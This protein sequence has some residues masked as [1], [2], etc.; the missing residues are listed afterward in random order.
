MTQWKQ[1]P[2]TQHQPGKTSGTGACASC[3]GKFELLRVPVLSQSTFQWKQRTNKAHHWVPSPR[4]CGMEGGVRSDA[5]K[6]RPWSNMRSLKKR[7]WT[8][9]FDFAFLTDSSWASARAIA[10]HRGVGSWKIKTL[11]HSS[12]LDSAVYVYVKLSSFI[13]SSHPS[14]FVIALV[15]LFNFRIGSN[16]FKL[17]QLLPAFVRMSDQRRSF[18]PDHVFKASAKFVPCLGCLVGND[19]AWHVSSSKPLIL[20]TSL[21]T[22]QTCIPKNPSY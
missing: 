16:M 6:K 13:L 20:G 8:P 19:K 7:D 5:T 12:D 17:V 4:L 14:T 15:Q 11:W 3:C 9:G 22:W 10:Q 18:P 1:N 21:E 2:H